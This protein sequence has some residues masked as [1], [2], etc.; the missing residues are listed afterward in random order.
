[1]SCTTEWGAEDASTTLNGTTWSNSATLTGGTL[2]VT[3]DFFTT[4]SAIPFASYFTATIKSFFEARG[5]WCV[6]HTGALTR[7]HGSLTDLRTALILEALSKCFCNT[8]GFRAST[9]AREC[10]HPTLATF[11]STL[12]RSVLATTTSL[13]TCCSPGTSS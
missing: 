13:K 12:A 3:E 2:E 11:G 10:A 6:L 4:T 5:I 1:L 7:E 9:T 8:R